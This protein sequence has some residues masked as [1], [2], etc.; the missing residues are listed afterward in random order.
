MKRTHR[1]TVIMGLATAVFGL[2]LI[3][4][5]VW[6]TRVGGTPAYLVG[7]IGYLLVG[8]LLIA[9]RGVAFWLHLLLFAAVLIWSFAETGFNQWTVFTALPRLDMTLL[10]A[11][12]LMLPWAWRGLAS[13]R[14]PA[15]TTGL[16]S[17]ALI[18]AGIGVMLS[19]PWVHHP[20]GTVADNGN[21]DDHVTLPATSASPDDW[22]SWGRTKGQ[23]RFSPLDQIN[24]DNVA[25]LQT[26]WT[27]RSGDMDHAYDESPHWG[28]EATPIK[29][30][31]TAYT[32]TPNAWVVALDAT[33]GKQQ[34]KFK[35]TGIDD[36]VNNFVNCRG[37]CLFQGPLQLSGTRR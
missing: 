27:Y 4:E 5:G 12:L 36:S 21:S 33:T 30:G 18:I 15:L 35:P 31:N 26:A 13:A 22:P 1:L 10:I 32:C 11:L 19:M 37:A 20:D 16:A 6:L 3:A 29:I 34:W 7:G 28:S 9:R 23:S 17:V 25:K 24:V 8:G 2:L 14:I